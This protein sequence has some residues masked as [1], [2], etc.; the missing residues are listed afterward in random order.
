MRPVFEQLMLKLQRRGLVEST[1]SGYQPNPAFTTAAE[2]ANEAQRQF[3]TEHP[4]HLPEAQLVAGNCAELGRILRCEKDAVHVLFVSAGAELLDHFYGDSLLTSHWLAAISAAVQEAAH[5]LPEGRGLRILE[6]G[7]GTGGLSAQVLPALERG[8]HSYTFTDVSAA[9]FSS[10]H[11]KLANFPE[12]ETKIFDLEKSATEQGFELGS[13]DFIIGTNVLH[14][15]TDIRAALRNLYQLLTPGGS[16]VFMDV[17][18]PQLWAEAV[19]GLTSGWWRF[20]DRDLRPVHPLLGRSQWETVLRETGFNETTSLPGLML[21]QGEGQI[22]ILARKAWQAPPTAEFGVE[23]PPEKSFLIFADQEGIGSSLA[24]RLRA[25]GI[26]CRIVFRGTAFAAKDTDTFMLRAVA[27]EDWHQLFGACAGEGAPE[28]IIY[29]WNLDT[30]IDDDGTIGTD[31]LL[32]LAQT[33]DST[34]PTTKLRIDS[35]TR[36][37]QAVGRDDSPTLVAQAPALGLM[38]VILNEYPNYACRGIDLPP[39]PSAADANLLWTELLRA[40]SEREVA[41][42]GEAR[43]VQRLE[44]GPSRHERML[45]PTIPLRLESRERGQIDALS[46]APFAQPSC[47]PGQVIIDVKAAGMNFRDVLKALALYPGEAPDARIFGDEVGGIITAVGSD[48]T[49]VSPGDRV[50][51]LAVF[52][53]STQTIA[54]ASDV[55]RIPS[56]LSFEEA[57]TI[58][59]VFMTSWHALKNVARLRKGERVLIHAGAGGVGMAGIQIAHH[60]GA[61]VIA[62]A[63]SAVKRGLLMAL[64]VKHVIDSRRGDFVE[65]VM[66]LTGRRGVDVVLN[67]LAGEA[68]PMGLSCLAEFG[69]FIEIGKRDIYQ[70]SRI[71]LRPL[72]CNASFHVVAMDA[73]FAGD[74]SLTRD[75]FVEVAD[76]VEHGALR[77]LPFRAFSAFNVDSAFRLMAGGK[78]I[79]KVIVSLPHSLLPRRGE[80]IAPQFEIKSDGCYLIT[81]AF[82][83]FGKVLANWL[84]QSG[85]RHL[86]LS[87]RNGASTP[88]AEAFVQNLRESGTQVHIVKADAGSS[89]DIAR[90]F[91]VI[92]QAGQPLRGIFHLAMAIDD[93][94]LSKLNRERMAAVIGPKAVGAWLLHEATR[95]MSLDCFVMFS[96]ISSIFGNP[97]QGNYVAANAFLDSLAHHRRALGLPALTINWGVLGGEGYVARNT[98]VAEFLA[99][100]GTTELSPAEVISILE[101]SLRAPG[102]QVAAIRV[103]WA[104]WRT[105]FRSMQA[106]PLL[107]RIFASVEGEE[108]AG[109]TSDWRNRIESASPEEKEAV[110]AQAVREVVGSVL[111]VKP[112]RLRDDQPLTDLGLDS[113][114]GVEIENSLEAAIGVAL[115]P[116][117]LMRARTI[118]QIAAL[119]ATHLGGSAPTAAASPAAA[120]IV[121]AEPDADMAEIDFDALSSEEID[122]LLGDDNNC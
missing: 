9:F 41:F 107:E 58:P 86:V 102:A 1:R 111:R 100:Q 87:S 65:A 101:S 17:A 77:P 50:F 8:L 46:F 79:G 110:I 16:L 103:D 18:T 95:D 118:G 59:V 88:E 84:V 36:G 12:V 42:R 48:V 61:E 89:A 25:A 43:Y 109:I 120:P 39:A 105:F 2:S 62:S 82:G 40:E 122:R 44:R 52:G 54:R 115:P 93:A 57:A 49:H 67:A 64:G 6:V 3:I 56:D 116:T 108:S 69:R 60:L 31:A 78:H 29:L 114:M 23:V 4:G 37:A 85:A 22:G 20:S 32:H 21:P 106:N 70:N 68:I 98:R 10:A 80:P 92:N 72:R 83:G 104:K 14:A 5:A 76:L 47:G 51:G 113:L 97:A 53:L 24:E 117:S 81:G 55:R 26:R 7:A 28:R 34:W 96:S 91:S 119:M 38:R 30:Q 94:V 19:F 15:V 121:A 74:K 35:V 112:D 11:Q 33:L 13:F 63:G 99:K 75:M 66:E 90:L 45:D 73:V 27:P 71:P